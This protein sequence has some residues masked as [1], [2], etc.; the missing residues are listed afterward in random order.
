MPDLACPLCGKEIRFH[1]QMT[2]HLANEHANK[3]VG[4]T[5]LECLPIKAIVIDKRG[6][7]YQKQNRKELCWLEAGN[8]D[9]LSTWQLVHTDNPI[10]L[11]VGE[12]IG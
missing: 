5:Q 6:E 9:D 8:S 11:V 12:S 10:Y 4:Y 3:Q 2:P 1:D 7:A